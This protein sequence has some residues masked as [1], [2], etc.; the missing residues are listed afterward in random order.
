M[1]ERNAIVLERYFNQMFGYNMKNNIKTNFFDYCELVECLEEYKNVLEEEE[2]IIQ[3]YDE[4]ANNIREK[5]KIQENLN[6]KN[7][8]LQEEISVIFQ[9][10]DDVKSTLKEKLE[11]IFANIQITND[12]TKENAEEFIDIITE[13]NEKSETR[14]NC[15]KDRRIKEN[16]YNKILNQV[17]DDYKDIDL[18]IEKR[19]KSFLKEETNEMEN[20]LKIKIRKN[21][22][23]E[24]VPFNSK[25]I[26]KA[27]ILSVDIQKRE[28]EILTNAFDK[29]NRLF[30]EIK[31]NNTKPDKHKKVIKDSKC[32]LEFLQALKDYLIQFLDNERLTSVNGK[33]EHDKLMEEACNNLEL[34][35]VQINNLYTLLL[36]EISNK[37]TK[38]AYTELYNVGYLN[39]LEKMAEEFDKEIKKLKLPV[40]IINPNYWRIDGMKKI[41]NVFYK[42]IT[43]YYGRDLLEF[44]PKEEEINDINEQ[45]MNVENLDEDEN[46]EKQIIDDN[47]KEKKEV[48]AGKSEIDKKIDMILGFDID[49]DDDYEDWDD[50]L[51]QDETD[52]IWD[53]EE[54]ENIEKPQINNK[55]E[56][57]DNEEDDDEFEDIDEDEW[58]D[59]WD[60]DDFLDEEDELEEDFEE[61]EE[62]SN[63]ETNDKKE[64]WENKFVNL[65]KNTK[66]LFGKLKK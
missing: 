51:E 32:K 19:A 13:F 35:L 17:L 12:K 50:E 41:Y 22:E 60:N 10:I 65:D 59:E 14:Q 55:F 43:E 66:G 5:Q 33:K 28:V 27:I 24:K 49:N 48:K 31:N 18:N 46:E 23:S 30:I 56:I 1:Y 39:E 38:K 42:C 9:N 57:E 34:D 3:D 63:K 64:I 15:S 36:K 40:A 20:D 37:V 16:Q 21:G 29:T 2:R 8:Q 7:N 4:I 11:N 58:D 6:Q 62:I 54:K 47:V 26:E 45:P 53:I 52:S 61:K 44:F 25:V